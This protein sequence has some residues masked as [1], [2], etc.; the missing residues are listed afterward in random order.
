MPYEQSKSGYMLSSDAISSQYITYLDIL[1]NHAMFVPRPLLGL[2]N[3]FPF[4]PPQ[5]YFP[6]SSTIS[7]TR[8][9]T[10]STTTSLSNDTQAR[11]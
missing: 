9:A 5:T 8:L 2:Y 3:L 11:D 10:I 6:S 4:P 7:I 1:P